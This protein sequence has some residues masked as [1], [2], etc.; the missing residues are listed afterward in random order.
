MA[1]QPGCGLGR[2]DIVVIVRHAL[3][4]ALDALGHVT[5]QAGNPAATEQ[6]HDDQEHDHPVHQREGTHFKYSC[7][8]TYLGHIIVIFQNG[9]PAQTLQHQIDR[10][11]QPGRTQIVDTGQVPAA[12]K[13]EM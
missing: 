8:A 13:P 2:G 7:K 10:I 12:A 9:L 1:L 3:L 5:H 11:K 4:E 6:Q